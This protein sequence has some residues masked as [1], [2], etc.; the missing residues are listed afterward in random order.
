[1]SQKVEGRGKYRTISEALRN[2]KRGRT[3]R[4]LD[5]AVYQETLRINSPSHHAGITLEA[6]RGAT[7]ETST[8][9]P[10]IL[11]DGVPGVT[12][13]GFRLHANGTR[14]EGGNLAILV[15]VKNGCPGLLLDRLLMEASRGGFYFGVQIVDQTDSGKQDAPLVVQKCLL[16][17]PAL[18]ISL[19]GEEGANLT[20]NPVTRIVLRD[21]AIEDAKQGIVISGV[22]RHIHVVGNRIWRA[23]LS[24][25]QLAHL[26]PGTTDI[27]I[28]N[29][30]FFECCYSFRLW[31]S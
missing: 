11:I 1:V 29:N 10:M 30:T 22:L 4:V 19:K 15:G 8:T 26:L 12:L 28:A 9:G 18:G 21:N 31:D 2:V 13:R 16:R 5:D 24:G 17:Q 20:P 6:A 23:E 3:V 7:I 14:L 25:L 27:L